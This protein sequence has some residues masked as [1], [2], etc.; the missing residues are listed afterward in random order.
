MPKKTS[1]PRRKPTP[2][3]L[4]DLDLEIRFME[5]LVQRDGGSMEALQVLGDDYTRR[6]RFQDGLRI[7]Q[8]LSQLR[9]RDAW[10]ITI[11]PAATR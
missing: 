5:G 10:C 2:Q 11:W 3:E 8:R 4:R 9:P 7:D 1:R 6:G